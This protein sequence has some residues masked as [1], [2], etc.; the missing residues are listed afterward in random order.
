MSSGVNDSGRDAVTVWSLESSICKCNI[1]ILYQSVSTF[2]WDSKQQQ[3]VLSGP[4][5]CDDLR[6]AETSS[7]TH[8]LLAHHWGSYYYLERR[9]DTV[10]RAPFG[11]RRKSLGRDKKLLLDT[12]SSSL[13]AAVNLRGVPLPVQRNPCLNWFSNNLAAIF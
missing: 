4:E 9:L 11:D 5:R 7:P 8:S 10:C 12:L 3:P 1:W 6:A 2:S 13:L